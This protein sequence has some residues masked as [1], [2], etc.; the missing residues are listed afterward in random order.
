MYCRVLA[1]REGIFAGTIDAIL[2]DSYRIIFDKVHGVGVG[3]VYRKM[4]RSVEGD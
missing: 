4:C 1:P 3:V 2:T